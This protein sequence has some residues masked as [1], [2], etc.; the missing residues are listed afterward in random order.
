MPPVRIT[1]EVEGQTVAERALAKVAE[2]GGRVESIKTVSERAGESLDRL[3]GR[4]QGL[5]RHVEQLG[6][7]FVRGRGGIS[8]WDLAL[9]AARSPVMALITAA[10]ALAFTLHLATTSALANADAIQKVQQ[11]SGFGVEASNQLAGAAKLTGASTDAVSSALERMSQEID[12]GGAGLARLGIGLRDNEGRLKT[13]GQ[14]LLE[15]QERLAG[16]GDNATRVALRNQLLGRSSGELAEFLGKSREEMAQL[17]A[18]AE[19]LN[20]MTEE[21][22]RRAESMKKAQAEVSE[23]WQGVAN[24]IANRAMPAQTQ[25]NKTQAEALSLLRQL[26]EWKPP[27]WFESIANIGKHLAGAA[28]GGALVMRATGQQPTSSLYLGDQLLAGPGVSQPQPQFDELGLGHTPYV[29][30]PSTSSGLQAP[31]P[32][33]RALTQARIAQAEQEQLA[34]VK[35]I[36]QG[37]LIAITRVEQVTLA[38]IAREEAG[39]RDALGR[40]L[41][42][43]SEFTQAEI[44]FAEQRRDAELKA[45]KERRDAELAAIQGTRSAEVGAISKR[46]AEIGAMGEGRKN[47]AIQ[48][49]ETDLAMRRAASVGQA[50]MAIAAAED[51]AA[52][53]T[54]ASHAKADQAI[55]DG[56]TKLV[57]IDQAL[58]AWELQHDAKVV[59]SA[60]KSTDERID[61]Q[62]RLTAALITAKGSES[63]IFE[64]GLADERN[65]QLA[66]AADNIKNNRDLAA[67]NEQIWDVY[68]AKLAKFDQDRT[69]AALAQLGTWQ[70]ATEDLASG[71]ASAIERSYGD[72][73]GVI[74]SFLAVA[75]ADTETSEEEKHRILETAARAEIELFENTEL[76]RSALVEQRIQRNATLYALEVTNFDSAENKKLRQTAANINAEVAARE[77]LVEAR[78]TVAANILTVEQKAA[79][80]ELA[81]QARTIDKLAA[82]RQRDVDNQ[83]KVN[84][85]RLAGINKAAADELAI[86]AGTVNGILAERQRL[87]DNLNVLNGAEEAFRQQ[88]LEGWAAQSQ[89][90]G[91]WGEFLAAQF[92]IGLTRGRDFYSNLTRFAQDFAQLA[93]RTL[94]DVFFDPTQ[95]KLEDLKNS[96]RRIFADFVSSQVVGSVGRMFADL[97]GVGQSAGVALAQTSSQTASAMGNARDA[98]QGLAVALNNAT[99]AS[100]GTP[101]ALTSLPTTTGGPASFQSNFT[102]LEGVKNAWSKFTSVSA[103]TQYVD[104]SVIAAGGGAGIEGGASSSL[105][106]GYQG[107]WGIDSLGAAAGYA[108]GIMNVGLG[109]YNLSQGKYMTGVGQLAGT[110]IGAYFGGPGGAALGGM[111]GGFVGGFLDDLFGFGDE[112]SWF[113]FPEALRKTLE[114]EAKA[115][116]QLGAGVANAQ[117]LTDLAK[118]IAE[119]Q[120][121]AAT[122]GQTAGGLFGI[123]GLPGATGTPHEGGQVADPNPHIQKIRDV[124]DKIVAAFTTEVETKLPQQAKRLLPS[125]LFDAFANGPL[126]RLTAR[127]EELRTST[128]AT[129][130][131]LQ[132]FEAEIQATQQLVLVYAQVREQAALLSRDQQVVTDAMIRS[133]AL[134]IDAAEQ[135]IVDAQ[136]RLAEA[137]TSTDQVAAIQALQTAVIAR[138]EL[139]KK[140][141][142]EIE[143]RI[144]SVLQ[145]TGSVFL[146]ARGFVAGQALAGGDAQPLLDLVHT[147]TAVAEDANSA[148]LK[149][150]A[151]TQAIQ[152]ALAGIPAAVQAGLVKGPEELVAG[153]VAAVGPAL[154]VLKG[155]IDEAFATGDLETAVALMAQSKDLAVSTGQALIAGVRQWEEAQVEAIRR[156]E[157]AQLAAYRR[158]LDAIETFGGQLVS[159]GSRWAALLMEQGDPSGVLLVVDAL[160]ALGEAAQS[161]ALKIFAATAAVQVIVE[162]IPAILA[163]GLANAGTIPAIYAGLGGAASNLTSAYQQAR[164]AGDWEQALK[165]LGTAATLAEQVA[166]ALI[167][168]VG[169]WERAESARITAAL[170]AALE[171]NALRKEANDLQIEGLRTQRAAA[172]K[173]AQASRDWL[174]IVDAGQKLIDDI[175]TGNASGLGAREALAYAESRLSIAEAAFAADRTPENASAVQEAIKLVLSS[176]QNVWRRPSPEYQKLED[177]MVSKLEA[178]QSVAGQFIT[179][180]KESAASLKSID[181]QIAVLVNANKDIEEENRRLR[182]ATEK[183]L[184]RIHDQAA[185]AVRAIKVDLASVLR[186]I[187]IEEMGILEQFG[188]EIDAAANTTELAIQNAATRSIEAARQAATGTIQAINA[189]LTGVLGWIG[190]N[191]EEAMRAQLLTQIQQ[192]NAITN[193]QSVQAFMAQCAKDTADALYSGSKSVAQLLEEILR[194]IPTHHTGID[195]TPGGLAILSADEAVLKPTDADLWRELRDG[196]GVLGP[197]DMRGETRRR[198]TRRA[199]RPA[200]VYE[201]ALVEAG[202][203]GSDDRKVE[204][205]FHFAPGTFVNVKNEEAFIR[206]MSEVVQGDIEKKMRTGW[207][208]KFVQGKG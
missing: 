162:A 144:G 21:Q 59:E 80:D 48:K 51:K 5:L 32:A 102:F 9:T 184:G 66:W 2:A 79:S 126:A 86:A 65:A 50:A 186:T 24:A 34:S 39:R 178:V 35:R 58:L 72:Q 113:K 81:I 1:F 36:E 38:A 177:A 26:A 167:D 31:S 116:E 107:S 163:S 157:Q 43:E 171:A 165:I 159:H 74:R 206:R 118:A 108:G 99:A 131:D 54:I 73:L 176:A 49:E 123:A 8:I 182:T 139:E 11:A 42:S 127:W 197:D 125:E 189:A 111:L 29:P 174:R 57:V 199:A 52:S 195:R 147:L 6:D 25:W 148:V 46:Q 130:E 156:V 196:S 23:G 175:K 95:V 143:A 202:S 112:G 103:T 100:G 37:R 188:P 145:T 17:I 172:E 149:Q 78:A 198:A 4:S 134:Q 164:G 201:P 140:L 180:E 84:V 20:P 114:A 192:L 132:A 91:K 56:K 151:A 183:E 190:A 55:A 160:R 83:I 158:A 203:G 92:T 169:E 68:N 67:V 109:A 3:G 75:M 110:A 76:A 30:M 62:T 41:I 193:G 136:S 205:H 60:Q 194:G 64:R 173:V 128:T 106:S 191:T 13:Q 28:P 69:Q 204:M 135:A 170:D 15:V 101:A 141:I 121:Y 122:L 187:A 19:R 45:I 16:V 179:P 153:V 168:G 90:A 207:R 133:H 181:D 138:Y 89:A 44:G 82:Q 63:E 47:P 71:G 115:I 40:G 27:E 120:T 61:L 14:L 87:I 93:E 155:M 154:G 97:L 119:Y 166:T 124:V 70:Q 98:A 200:E 88:G 152:A 33:D 142:G 85:E 161:T 94:S 22:I 77:T 146:S 10:G 129:V 150:W 117:S 137:V 185:E 7:G 105:L 53:A 12:S 208:R 104:P 18:T 96:V